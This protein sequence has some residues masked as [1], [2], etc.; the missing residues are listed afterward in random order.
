MLSARPTAKKTTCGATEFQRLHQQYLPFAKKHQPEHPG[1][2]VYEMMRLDSTI[3]GF[4]VTEDDRVVGVVTRN[5][6][7]NRVSGRYGFLLFVNKPVN[8]L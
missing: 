2:Q 6:L 5:E 8:G 3:P 1:F 7:F 4:C